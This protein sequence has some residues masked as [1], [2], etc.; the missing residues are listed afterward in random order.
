MV[1]DAEPEH[2]RIAEPER[3]PCEEADLGDVDRVQPPGGVDAIAHRAARE[4][5]GA[6]I[7]PDRI[8]GEGGERVDAV[9]N[10]IMADG[11]DREQVIEG[12]GEIARGDEQ[13]GEQDLTRFGLLDGIEDVVDIDAAEH[14]EEHVAGDPDDEDADRNS[15]PVQ[16][17]F[18]VQKRWPCVWRPASRAP[19]QT[20][21]NDV[22]VPRCGEIGPAGNAGKPTFR[23]GL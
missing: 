16:D 23:D 17:L 9:G 11:S 13:A 14:V 21:V 2:G 10:V 12:Q 22:G 6:D 15:H 19:F 18:L 7:V 3:Q 8:G 20:F 4:H 5:A 1:G